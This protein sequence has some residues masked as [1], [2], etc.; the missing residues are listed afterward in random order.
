M[1]SQRDYKHKL[2]ASVLQAYAERGSTLDVAIFEYSA[3]R[4]A[5][6]PSRRSQT[7]N[8]CD[9]FYKFA[10]LLHGQQPSGQAAH[11][12]NMTPQV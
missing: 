4:P 5:C 9:D 10:A 1:G 11:S 6:G 7:R 2:I 3:I 8:F 12:N